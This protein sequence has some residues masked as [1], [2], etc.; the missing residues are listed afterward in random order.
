[1]ALF[2]SDLGFTCSGLTIIFHIPCMKKGE[3]LIQVSHVKLSKSWG[4]IMIF[5]ISHLPR[6]REQ[7]KQYFDEHGYE[8][9]LAPHRENVFEL[10]R[11]VKP[12]VLVLDLYLT[13]PSTKEVLQQIRMEGYQGKVV[14]LAGPSSGDLL[15]QINRLGT[16]QVIG[17]PQFI[18]GTIN[19]EQLESTIR[20]VV[21]P[22]IASRAHELFVTQGGKD[23]HGQDDWL[24]AE[25]EIL[26]KKKT[27]NS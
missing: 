9:C 21:H 1:M 18:E 15:A 20:S 3:R 23:C 13:T 22:I 25:Q 7:L 11:Q 8:I 14:L 5:I 17:G 2:H 4:V 16:D 6:H 10:V 24:Q 27:S 12:H 26:F 19:F